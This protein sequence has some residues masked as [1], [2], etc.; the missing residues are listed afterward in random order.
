[1]IYLKIQHVYS[2]LADEQALPPGEILTGSQQWGVMKTMA[3]SLAGRA[4]LLDLHSFSLHEISQSDRLSPWVVRWLESPDEFLANRQTRHMSIKPLYEQLWRGFLPEAQFLEAGVIPDFLHAY[5]RTYIERDVRLM[6]GISDLQVFGRFLQLVCALTAQEINFSQL[7]RELGLTPQT[8]Q[9]WLDILKSTFQWFELPVYSR[10]PVKRLTNKPKGYI[11][12][13]GLACLTQAISV[14][15]T[16]GGHPLWGAL[17]ETAVVAEF[18]KQTAFL[19]PQPNF[20]HWRT[21]SGAEVDVL[22][23]YNGIIYPIEIKAKTNPAR[24]DSMGISAFRK[25]YPRQSIAK[26]LVIAPCPAVIPLSEHDYAVPWD[27]V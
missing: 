9:R 23:E 19:S 15:K 14:P 25:S 22:L 18:K 7:G 27:L 16:I 5:Q 2:K 13:T 1:M 6:A 17:F 3:E 8:A 24:R 12:D 10:N 26:G 20:Y 11:A 21:Y 4:V